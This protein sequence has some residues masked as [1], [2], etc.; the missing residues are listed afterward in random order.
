M[1]TL[2]VP[3][4]IHD[5]LKASVEKTGEILT[6][7]KNTGA[8]TNKPYNDGA[9][10]IIERRVIEHSDDIGEETNK[11]HT[12]NGIENGVENRVAD[13]EN[14]KNGAETSEQNVSKFNWFW[15]RGTVDDNVKQV[16]DPHINESIDT[17]NDVNG[18]EHKSDERTDRPN[19]IVNDDENNNTVD[20][21]R[22][23]NLIEDA[24]LSK[25]ASEPAE[26][27]NEISPENRNWVDYVIPFK[28]QPTETTPLIDKQSVHPVP[29]SSWFS[30]G[31]RDP[32]GE[33]DVEEDDDGR[34]H[35]LRDARLK[36]ENSTDSIN[37]AYKY[38]HANTYRRRQLELVV[39]DT[40]TETSPIK[41]NSKKY[42]LTPNEVQ[43]RVIQV[44][45]YKDLLDKKPSLVLPDID[46]NFRS[47]TWQTRVR[48]L[49]EGY[50]LKNPIPLHLYKM[51][52]YQITTRK[53]HVKKIVI[54]GVHSFLPIKIVRK[55]IGQSSANGLTLVKEATKAI[56]YWLKNNDI[57][58]Y[59]IQSIVL[60]GQGTINDRVDKSLKMLQNWHETLAQ[61]DFIYVVSYSH[62]VP[63]AINI[64][65]ELVQKLSNKKYGLLSLN[66]I[67]D[68]VFG[69]IEQ[70][71]INRG[72]TAYENEI[73]NE[74]IDLLQPETQLSL[75]IMQSLVV[76]A[77]YNA[78]IMFAGSINDQF[79][80][81]TSTL[82]NQFHHP[83]M[84]RLL[85]LD[86][87]HE[88]PDFIVTLFE[89]MTIMKNKGVYNDHNLLRDLSILCQGTT[90]GG[91]GKILYDSNVYL[92]GIKHSLETT[93]LVN[94]YP[95]DIHYDFPTNNLFVLPWNIRGLLQELLK[96]KNIH[97]L[98]LI[99][100]LQHDF[101]QWE[102]NTRVW[103]DIKLA[104]DAF[105]DM[106][107][108]DL[109]I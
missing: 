63:V 100:Q 69:N 109:I 77:K 106:N 40:A 28:R 84:Y 97:N 43:E 57:G 98:K 86:Q 73:L 11:V 89:I 58:E 52:N 83:N 10:E 45:N 55:L 108:E 82:C 92:M 68:G 13:K 102:P 29:S 35:H 72:N 8:D 60:E 25:T 85:Y 30:W 87:D 1:S 70:K 4:S 96:I 59:D 2:E 48:L 24:S 61:S 104:F 79:T 6:Q 46:R 67:L 37:Y 23:Q 38:I 21:S 39:I 94:Q 42:P 5:T 66:G 80:P 101:K 36:I 9:G 75:Q 90:N 33:E 32:S 65:L 64:M 54:I 14:I 76:L 34:R 31:N 49:Y 107:L 53:Q 7:D 20:N 93:N 47:I 27:G 3:P 17:L 71:L 19:D 103:R 56:K 50:L 22:Q 44:N 88:V 41:F 99:G 105:D 62:G 16:L 26:S 12:E 51:P 78:K 91:H 74:L 81:L 15:S 95:M 18:A